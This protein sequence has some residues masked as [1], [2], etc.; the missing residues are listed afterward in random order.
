MRKF[1][2]FSVILV[3]IYLELFRR[4]F[5]DSWPSSN[6]RLADS[7]HVKAILVEVHYDSLPSTYRCLSE[8]LFCFIGSA[9]KQLQFVAVDIFP[10]YRKGQIWSCV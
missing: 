5:R 3:H 6:I 2:H 1:S 9:S 8:D 7:C 10:G 4:E